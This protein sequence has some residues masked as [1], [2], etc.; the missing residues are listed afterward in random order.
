MHV[1]EPSTNPLKAMIWKLKT[2]RKIKHFLWQAL[3]DSM[4]TCSRLAD[5]HCGTDRMCPRCGTEEETIN[6]CLF[7]CPPAIQTWA[8]S[9]IRYTIISGILPELLSSREF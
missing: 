3:S 1:S 9:D 7:S 5:R 8:L 4:A 2:S 6:H